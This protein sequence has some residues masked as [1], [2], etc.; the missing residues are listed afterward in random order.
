[1]RIGVVVKV[2]PDKKIGFIHSDDLHEDVFF[3][4]TKVTNVGTA[5]LAEGDEVEYEVDELARINKTR[6][7]ATFVR[8]SVR[9]LEMKLHPSDAPKLRAKHHPKARK[10]R[11]TWRGGKGSRSSADEQTDTPS[12]AERPPEPP[13]E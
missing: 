6:L 5:D 10:A 7:Q 8:R 1:M 11:P 9:P 3:H 13:Q 12:S 4:F 2:I